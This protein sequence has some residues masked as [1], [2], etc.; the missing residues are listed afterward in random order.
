MNRRSLVVLI[1]LLLT[2]IIAALLIFVV[3]PGGAQKTR[4]NVLASAEYYLEKGDYERALNLVDSLLIKNAGDIDARALRDRAIEAKTKAEAEKAEAARREGLSSQREIAST[5]DKLGQK[6][7]T[8][9]DSQTTNSVASATTQSDAARAKA[10]AEARA[11]AEA[12]AQRKA[13]EAA[14]RK[15]EADAEAARRKAQEEELSQK[16]KELQAKMRTVN[17]LVERGMK[18]VDGGDFKTGERLFDEAKSKLPE[19]EDKFASQKL[20]DIAESLYSGSRKYP[21]AEADAALQQAIQTARDAKKKDSSNAAPYYTLGKINSDLNQMDNAI[22]ELKQAV[23]LDPKNYLY[24]YALGLAY[25]KARRYEEARQSFSATTT[26]N[27][28]LSED[29]IISV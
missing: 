6:L 25:F 22:T 13:E 20:A 19:G 7:G 2:L 28:S 4:L 3:I 21:G 16:S 8:R 24:S 15:A 17:D 26:L 23:S 11:K 14:Q 10:E 12:E 1:T 5:L 27:P 18:A 29:F 9:Q